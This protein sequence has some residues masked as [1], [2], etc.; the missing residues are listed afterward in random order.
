MK[1]VKTNRDT[2]PTKKL[3]LQIRKSF[4]RRLKVGNRL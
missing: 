4:L 3:K 1:L 2:L